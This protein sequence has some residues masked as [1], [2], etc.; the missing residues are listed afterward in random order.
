MSLSIKVRIAEQGASAPRRYF[1]VL[2]EAFAVSG[3][4]LAMMRL[5]AQ[6]HLGHCA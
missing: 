5:S 2:A 3:K 6:T 1:A 4:E